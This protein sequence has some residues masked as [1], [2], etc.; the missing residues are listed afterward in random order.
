MPQERALV[1]LLMVL[2][3]HRRRSHTSGFFVRVDP[4]LH[5][6]V[7]DFYNGDFTESI[8]DEKAEMSQYELQFMQNA[9]ETV[10]LKDGHYQISFWPFLSIFKMPSFFEYS[11]FFGAVFCIE[12]L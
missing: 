5:Q 2:W 10:K 11:S 7:E 9:E 6:M 12:Q 4:E 3:R 1:G 8:V